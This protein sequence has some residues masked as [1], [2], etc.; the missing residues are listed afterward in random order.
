VD[1]IYSAAVSPREAQ[2]TLE[3]WQSAGHMITAGEEAAP[4]IASMVDLAKQ[5]GG[6]AFYNANGVLDSIQRAVDDARVSYLLG[7]YPPESAWD[8]KYHE[9]GIKV[10]RSGVQ[11]RGR[12]GYF[13]GV[14][15]ADSMDD[16]AEAL[17]VAAASPLEGAAI[18][19]K[20]NVESNP[21]TWYGQDIVLMIDPH[22]LRF[23]Q[24]S[25]HMRA[26]VDVELVQ[27]AG[28]GRTLGGVKDTLLYAL[29]PDSY[30][31]A[32]SD[33]LFLDEKLTVLPSASRVRVV[34]RDVSTG[35]V[36]SVSLRVLRAD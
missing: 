35:A 25:D 15:K 9:I 27:Q 28:N 17:R 19:I 7:F 3:T 2:G 23:E 31:R 26:V 10:N 33:G 13:A 14:P 22:D 34:V 16:R 1:R 8:G 6:L 4:R 21:L 5:T 11:V 32:L 20:V 29:L 24:V 18:G 36:G 30:E 12:K